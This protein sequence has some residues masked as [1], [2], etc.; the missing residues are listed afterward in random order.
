MQLRG[1][2][3][4]RTSTCFTASLRKELICNSSAV[5][6]PVCATVGGVEDDRASCTRVSAHGRRESSS[7]ISSGDSSTQSRIFTRQ[8]GCDRRRRNDLRVSPIGLNQS[9]PSILIGAEL[10]QRRL[11]AAQ[12]FNRFSNLRTRHVVVVSRQSHSSQDTNDRHNDHQ[13]DEGE[14]L[15]HG[16]CD[17]T[18]VHSLTPGR[19]VVTPGNLPGAR[20]LPQH[21]CHPLGAPFP[22]RTCHL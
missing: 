18:T 5:A 7:R 8:I 1:R 19:L 21:L 11:Q 20:Y 17:G 2:C 10:C 22:Y 4:S 16:T 9:R 3:G 12:Q 13:F 14:T 15:L 6:A